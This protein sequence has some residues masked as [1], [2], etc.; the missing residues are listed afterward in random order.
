MFLFSP[1]ECVKGSFGAGCVQQCQCQNQARCHP[2]NGTC[3]CSPGFAGAH[4][5]KSK[6][7]F[8]SHH[9]LSVESLD[10]SV[11]SALGFTHC[12]GQTSRQNKA[13]RFQEWSYFQFS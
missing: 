2:V 8:V 1:S 13:T 12:L 4:C 11:P 3:T 5:E 7:S 10:G 9:W 6:S